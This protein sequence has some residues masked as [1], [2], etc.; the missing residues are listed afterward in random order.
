MNFFPCHP[1]RSKRSFAPRSR[2]PEGA[3]QFWPVRATAQRSQRRWRSQQNEPEPTVFCCYRLI[4]R[5]RNRTALPPTLK[6]FARPPDW[7]SSST[8]ATM[9]LSAKPPC[10]GLCDKCPNL[11]GY[12][13]GIGDI[14]LMT[15][16]YC[17]LGDRL[18]YIGGLRRRKHSRCL[19]WRWAS[20]HIRLLFSILC[21]GL[22]QNFTPPC[23]VAI[24]TMCKPVCAISFCL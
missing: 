3:F 7:E 19:I 1:P 17:R 15:R 11:V 20:R 22:R 8:I 12:K 5:N 10:S 13:D 9:R 6:Q 21:P 16:V 4:S 18:T 14:E 2:K 23:G 24:A